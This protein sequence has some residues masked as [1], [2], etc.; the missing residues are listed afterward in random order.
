MVNAAIKVGIDLHLFR[1]MCEAAQPLTIPL[2][3]NGAIE[4]K[5]VFLS[6]LRRIK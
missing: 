1:T 2:L 3:L 4:A 5:P 6:M